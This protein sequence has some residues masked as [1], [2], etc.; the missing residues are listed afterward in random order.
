VDSGLCIHD[1]PG[2]K[3]GSLNMIPIGASII[4]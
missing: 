4:T 3:G 2:I 1:P